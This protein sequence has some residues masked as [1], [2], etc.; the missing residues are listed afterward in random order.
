MIWRIGRRWAALGLAVTLASACGGEDPVTPNPTVDS[1]V[2]TWDAVVL[3]MTPAGSSSPVV[4]V[5]EFGEFF[6]VVQP[7][8]QY[9][10][11]LSLPT[12]PGVEIGQ[13]SVVGST[14]RLD[15]SVP[16]GEASTSTYTFQSPDYLILDGATEFDFNFDGTNDPAEAHFELQRR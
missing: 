15:P 6:I 14:I 13:L 16:A 5:L 7:S 4:D 12:G 1:F 2:G 10:A 8:G 9:T 11:T 3:T